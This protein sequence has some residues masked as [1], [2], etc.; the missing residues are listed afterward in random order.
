MPSLGPRLYTKA[1]AIEAC[2]RDDFQYGQGLRFEVNKLQEVVHK[3]AQPTT[4]AVFSGRSCKVRLVSVEVKAGFLRGGSEII[5]YNLPADISEPYRSLGDIEY[6][7]VLDCLLEAKPAPFFG[8]VHTYTVEVGEL[9]PA[10]PGLGLALG[11][12]LETPSHRGSQLFT[13]GIAQSSGKKG[14]GWTNDMVEIMNARNSIAP[15]PQAAPPPPP[16]PAPAPQ[17]KPSVE[18]HRELHRRYSCDAKDCPSRDP[19]VEYRWC[20][21]DKQNIHHKLGTEDLNEWKKAI[22]QE[23]ATISNPPFELGIRFAKAVAYGAGQ[24]GGSSGGQYST[25]RGT[26]A[27]GNTTQNVNISLGQWAPPHLLS[28]LQNSTAQMGIP[29]GDREYELPR[30]PPAPSFALPN[31]AFSLP[32]R[33]SSPPT[34]PSAS[35]GQFIEFFTIQHLGRDRAARQAIRRLNEAASIA[36]IS[37]GDLRKLGTSWFQQFGMPAELLPLLQ[38]EAKRYCKN[39]AAIL[40][41]GSSGEDAGSSPDL[42]TPALPRAPRS[43]SEASAANNLLDLSQGVGRK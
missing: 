7:D 10:T 13:P 40:E 41:D 36:K 19:A 38:S 42:G 4:E 33:S 25:G 6:G 27:A 2:E 30:F 28:A 39:Y 1:I 5:Q 3:S 15:A 23:Q 21:V 22:L 16:A 9:I 35:I 12:G 26:K 18:I 32:I 20:F 24:P 43:P 34:V 37:I 8:V 29:S 17:L 14:R 31:S 11:A